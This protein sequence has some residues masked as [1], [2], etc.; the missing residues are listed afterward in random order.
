[1]THIVL[2]AHD[3]KKDFTLT[4]TQLHGPES[5]VFI[6]TFVQ[7][8]LVSIE[9]HLIQVFLDICKHAGLLLMFFLSVKEFILEGSMSLFDRHE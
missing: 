8:I 1:V 5:F 4:L 7:D 9:F 2:Q 3:F 6:F